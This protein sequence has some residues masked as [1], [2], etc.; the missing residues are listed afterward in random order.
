MPLLSNE[1]NRRNWSA[2]ICQDVDVTIERLFTV[3]ADIRPTSGVRNIELFAPAKLEEILLNE[4]VIRSKQIACTTSTRN[5]IEGA[6]I[7]WSFQL[8][9]LF[10]HDPNSKF[11]LTTAT[12]FDEIDYW[13]SRTEV[14]ENVCV[15][16]F[17]GQLKRIGDLVLFINSVYGVTYKDMLQRAKVELVRAKDLVV[18]MN[19]LEPQ[20]NSLRTSDFDKMADLVGPV[21][22]CLALMWARISHYRPADWQR[23]FRMVC[24]LV[25]QEAS[26]HLDASSMFQA[27][28]EEL[29]NRLDMAV[30]LIELIE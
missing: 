20:L 29:A 1:L 25:Q 27:D 8:D 15:Q 12:P 5:M 14:L 7:K 10:T 13:R 2:E 16:L 24:N 19:A 28:E 9:E 30:N 3:F 26:R 11:N 23:L 18:Y 22:H 6:V 21:L 4:A 17:E